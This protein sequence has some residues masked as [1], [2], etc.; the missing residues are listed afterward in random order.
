VACCALR[1]VKPPSFF[2][3]GPFVLATL[4]GASA[5]ATDDGGYP[6]ER[7]SSPESDAAL[8]LVRE[9]DSIYVAR[10]A[11]LDRIDAATGVITE[12]AGADWAKCPRDPQITWLTTSLDFAY[13]NIVVHGS[14]LY[15]IAQECG[16]WSFDVAT[17]EKHMLVDPTS[18]TKK[19]RFDAEG[20]FPEGAT[21]NGKTGPDWSYAWGMALAADGDGL[22]GCFQAV[23]RAP[24]GSGASESTTQLELWSFSTE[25]TPREM[26][27]SV[28]REGAATGSD[29]YCKQVLV[30]DASILFSTD[31]SIL[32]WDRQTRALTTVV[33]G[34]RY[35]PEGLAQDASDVFY[36][37]A[38]N[39]VRRVS[40]RG[41]DPVVLR[42]SS[43]SP[44]EP[45]RLKVTLDGN[46]VYFH[47]GYSLVRMNKDGSDVTVVAEGGEDDW[48]LPMT[49]G[50]ADRHIY[51]ERMTRGDGTPTPGAPSSEPSWMGSLFRAPR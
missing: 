42:A 22:V 7:V 35:G 4:A 49:L 24:G 31:R 26:L 6:S 3:F 47:E 18:A 44:S 34:F 2:F 27:T 36:I 1:R 39:D 23:E 28:S 12:I 48:V 15:L 38:E 50:I 20:I 14:A 9:G 37:G 21:W 51:F 33:S 30:D 5:C 29:G 40:R 19:A 16:L 8:A 13:P 45:T 10:P 17:K 41:G 46:H 43:H 25:G 32:R 11:R